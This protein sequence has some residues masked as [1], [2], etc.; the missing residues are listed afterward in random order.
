MAQASSQNS[1]TFQTNGGIGLTSDSLWQIVAVAG[2]VVLLCFVL[3]IA[4]KKK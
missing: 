3:W 2:A 1:S 4:F